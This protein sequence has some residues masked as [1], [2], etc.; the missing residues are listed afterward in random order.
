MIRNECHARIVELDSD[1][2]VLRLQRTE[3]H[4]ATKVMYR[5]VF[6]MVFL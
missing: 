5:V 4:G 1:A 3:S 2:R 6:V